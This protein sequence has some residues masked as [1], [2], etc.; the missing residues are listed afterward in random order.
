MDWVN[1]IPGSH[2]FLSF[3]LVYVTFYSLFS[4][5]RGLYKFA[6]S[7]KFSGSEVKALPATE[8]EK[9]SSDGW[10]F[11]HFDTSKKSDSELN[12]WNI[13]NDTYRYFS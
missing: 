12:R 5:A 9:M 13:H 1:S 4:T 11:D 7:L 3:G 6:L 8:R 2:A 10:G